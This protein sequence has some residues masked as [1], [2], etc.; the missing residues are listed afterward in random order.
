MSKEKPSQESDAKILKP[1]LCDIDWLSLK[2]Q[3]E[4][5]GNLEVILGVENHMEQVHLSNNN[6]A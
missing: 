1:R 6:R 5:H 3:M 4:T 2:K